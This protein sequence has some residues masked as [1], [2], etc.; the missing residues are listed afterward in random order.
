M[1]EIF[2]LKITCE[3]GFNYKFEFNSLK[4]LRTE[5]NK[6]LKNIDET[7]LYN[8]EISFEG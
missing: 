3:M 5:L 1:N 4:A 7:P 8:I 2:I 6:W